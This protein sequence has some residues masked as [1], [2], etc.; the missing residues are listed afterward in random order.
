[1]F[2]ETVFEALLEDSLLGKLVLDES[3]PVV[4]VLVESV[5]DDSVIVE[6]LGD[7]V[8]VESLFD[9]AVVVKVAAVVLKTALQQPDN[10]AYDEVVLNSIVMDATESLSV[11]RHKIP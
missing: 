9:N 1:M 5:F 6:S 2:D 8:V 3:L 7:S 4:S 11:H 10:Q